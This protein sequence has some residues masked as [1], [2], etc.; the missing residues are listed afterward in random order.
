MKKTTL[1][2][3]LFVAW[4]Q[5]ALAQWGAPADAD[6]KYAKDLV[7]AGSVAPDFKMKALDGKTV[8]LSKLAK[9]RWTLIDFWAS[10]CPDC[11]KDIPNVKRMLSDFAPKGVQFV[12]VSFDTDAD[13][14]KAAV[15]KYGLDYT[16]VSELKKMRESDVAQT[17]GVKWIPSMVL[18]NPEGKVVLST[19][20]SDKMEKTLTETFAPRERGGEKAR[21]IHNPRRSFLAYRSRQRLLQQI[22]QI[23]RS[24]RLSVAEQQILRLVQLHRLPECI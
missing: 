22:R 20:L 7:A 13:A 2:L 8:K 17:F 4:S 15:E 24:R 6:A 3:M 19:V 9:G 1:I 18:L 16:Q 23:S 11:R 14:W 21:H 12:G 10:W 5:L